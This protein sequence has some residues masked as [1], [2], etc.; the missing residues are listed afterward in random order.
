MSDQSIE[1]LRDDP[2]DDPNLVQSKIVPVPSHMDYPHLVDLNDFM[3]SHGS[4]E[5]LTILDYG[6][7][8]SPYKS[9]FP[10]SDYRRA[11]ITNA[12]ALRYKIRPDSTIAEA[13]GT[14]DLI[15]STQVAE[16]VPNPDV[17]FK[18]C[19]RLLKPGG[20]LILSTH[21]IWDEHGSPYDFQR[22]TDSG[23]SRDIKSAG[24]LQPDIYKL[25]CGMRAALLIFTRTLFTTTPPVPLLRRFL[26]KSFRWFYSK[27]F[28][29]LYQLGD[30]W[31]PED[32]IVKVVEGGAPTPVWYVVIAAIAKK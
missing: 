13:D 18:E 10:K 30:R 19:F 17:Y 28:S 3:K 23:L 32:K 2:W 6:A 1:T 5:A 27:F 4:S 24:F 15:I 20:K 22:W 7:G 14:F 21:G 12:S 25:T 31:W 26:F 8:A 16:H 9:Y 11:D 29:Y